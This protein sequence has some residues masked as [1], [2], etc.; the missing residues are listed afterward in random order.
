MTSLA[1]FTFVKLTAPSPQREAQK[2]KVS[3]CKDALSIVV[4]WSFS[5]AAEF[6]GWAANWHFQFPKF[7]DMAYCLSF[8]IGDW[9]CPA[10]PG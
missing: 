6:A 9:A 2:I 8:R 1:V 10:L 4:N 5:T 3:L 7:P